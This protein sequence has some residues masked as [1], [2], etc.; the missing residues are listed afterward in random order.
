[1]EKNW[2]VSHPDKYK[3]EVKLHGTTIYR[4]ELY[5][6]DAGYLEPLSIR[7]HIT[8]VLKDITSLSQITTLAK[9]VHFNK[10]KLYMT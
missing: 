9:E 4:C 7:H 1:M 8:F 2:C 10:F 3:F 5:I 6:D